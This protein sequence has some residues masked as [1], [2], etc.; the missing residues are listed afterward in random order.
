MKALCEKCGGSGVVTCE[1]DGHKN[2]GREYA[3][4]VP[5]VGLFEF[6]GD[7]MT[8]RTERKSSLHLCFCSMAPDVQARFPEPKKA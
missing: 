6:E 7:T 3:I 2:C 4:E 5:V 1:Q 8:Y